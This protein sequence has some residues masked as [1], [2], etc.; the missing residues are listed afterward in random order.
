M[1]AA[2]FASDLGFHIDLKRGFDLTC[3]GQLGRDVGAAGLGCRKIF[4]F[5]NRGKRR[6]AL[7]EGGSSKNKNEED[8]GEVFGHGAL[9]LQSQGVF[10]TNTAAAAV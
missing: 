9:T 3:K 4:D 6:P 5:F 1:D 8:Y 10:S 7:V 2:D